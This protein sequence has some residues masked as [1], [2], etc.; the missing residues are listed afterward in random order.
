MLKKVFLAAVASLILAGATVSVQPTP[1]DAKIF[2]GCFKAAK[3]AGVKGFK[4][5]KEYRK[6]CRAHYKAA[7]HAK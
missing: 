7:K 1:A 6:E 5:R 2:H 4:A 3:A